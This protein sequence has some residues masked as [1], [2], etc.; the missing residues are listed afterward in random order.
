MIRTPLRLNPALLAAVLDAS[1]NAPSRRVNV[2][3][4]QQSPTP[5]SDD[6][7]WIGNVYTDDPAAYAHFDI[8]GL[9]NIYRHFPQLVDSCVTM[10]GSQTGLDFQPSNVVLIRTLGSIQMHKDLG[11][12]RCKF[13]FGIR[14]SQAA[15]TLLYDDNRRLLHAERLQDG[16]GYLLNSSMFHSV[17]A[18]PGQ[19][20]Y[21]YFLT[22]TT[23][24]DVQTVLYRTGYAVPP[25]LHH[26]LYPTQL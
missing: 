4:T 3:N 7:E 14:N 5:L 9:R 22:F 25:E 21:R 12:H 13:N 2:R 1:V 24:L 6:L 10:M 19:T 23:S 17:E 16:V 8:S 18:D 11:A 26:A 20:E 15:R